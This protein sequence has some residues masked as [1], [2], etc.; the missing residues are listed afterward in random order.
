MKFK[1]PPPFFKGVL[2]LFG[3]MFFAL[4][5]VFLFADSPQDQRESAAIRAVVINELGIRAL[6]DNAAEPEIKSM[7]EKIAAARMR[8][9]S[10]GDPKM[11]R[12]YEYWVGRFEK[13]LDDQQA[14]AGR[15]AAALAA[16]G[17][18]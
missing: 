18:S 13:L 17:K 12:S 1:R 11:R 2:I 15:R 4:F 10:V 5:L 7:R 6:S 8:I 9:A 14:D 3:V 16:L